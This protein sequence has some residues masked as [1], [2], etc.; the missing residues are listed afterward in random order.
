MAGHKAQSGSRNNTSLAIQK[1]NAAPVATSTEKLSQTLGPESFVGRCKHANQ[2]FHIQHNLRSQSRGETTT[3][4][5]K[6]IRKNLRK[7]KERDE[8]KKKE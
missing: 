5:D 8:Q 1:S 7:Q 2:S 3:K 4:I 6:I